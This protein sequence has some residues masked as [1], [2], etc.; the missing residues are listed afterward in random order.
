MTINHMVVA[1]HWINIWLRASEI[2][3]KGASKRPPVLLLI[4]GVPLLFVSGWLGGQMVHVYGACRP[5]QS[6]ARSRP[7]DRSG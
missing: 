5:S 2:N 3:V 6:I 4:I 1:L 7:K